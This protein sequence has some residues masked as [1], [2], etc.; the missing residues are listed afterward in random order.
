VAIRI[1]AIVV[2]AG[3]TSMSAAGQAP[4]RRAGGLS[5]A[6]ESLAGIDT[7][8]YYCAGC[9]GRQ[10]I[11]DGPVASSLKT[12]VP[13]LTTLAAR[14][15]GV[16][17]RDRVRAAVANTERPVTAHGSGDMPVWESMFNVLERSSDRTRIRIDGVVA[18][19]ETLQQRAQPSATLGRAVFATYC[20]TC[21][22]TDARGGGP[23]A[24][25][26]RRDVPDLTQFA[27]RNGGMFPSVR[28]ARIIDG[29][30]VRAH[31]S[32]EM[33]VWGDAFRRTPGGSTPE[34]VADRIAALTA[35]LESIQ[36]R[37]G[38]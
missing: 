31:G 17:P 25:E 18:Y 20:A 34:A 9:H 14:H 24:A 35:Y 10:G 11:G 7:Y 1:I 28:V 37:N 23:M 2:L 5:P 32:T 36:Q 22:G 12:P 4:A 6:I 19:V 16:F 3:L 26:L 21:H 15:G 27:V 29:R 8:N 30:E 13:D 38:E 33:P